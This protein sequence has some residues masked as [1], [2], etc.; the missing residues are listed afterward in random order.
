MWQIYTATLYDTSVSTGTADNTG[1]DNTDMGIPTALIDIGYKKQLAA[2]PS[3][4]LPTAD[5]ENRLKFLAMDGPSSNSGDTQEDRQ[6]REIAKYLASLGQMPMVGNIPQGDSNSTGNATHNAIKSQPDGGNRL[7]MSGV[8]VT[9]RN[10]TP[11]VPQR[12]PER[13][14]EQLPERLPERLLERLPERL[15]ERLS[16][17]IPER[18]LQEIPERRLPAGLLER[19][20]ERLPDGLSSVEKSEM[21]QLGCKLV[22]KKDHVS[23]TASEVDS[24]LSSSPLTVNRVT[25]PESC[26]NASAKLQVSRS[27]MDAPQMQHTLTSQTNGIGVSSSGQQ[28]EQ[29]VYSMPSGLAENGTLAEGFSATMQAN[30]FA[31]TTDGYEGQENGLTVYPT[32]VMTPAKHKLTLPTTGFTPEPRQRTS[33]IGSFPGNYAIAGKY[34]FYPVCQCEAQ[35]RL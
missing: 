31:A 8:N 4:T 11:V 19:L 12:T 29:A 34:L 16:E 26:Q 13:L 1:H 17:R 24:Y 7:H 18:L 21:A 33:S 3:V 10:F 6:R 32:Q 20:L 23:E 35:S 22:V 5:R 15:S 27:M 14:P 25:T 2:Y 30:A 28:N 9:S